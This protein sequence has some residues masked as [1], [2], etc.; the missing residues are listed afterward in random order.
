[1]SNQSFQAGTLVKRQDANGFTWVLRYTKD[2]KRKAMILGTHE[3]LPTEGHAKLKAADKI[4]LINSDKPI[5]TFGQLVER[6][7]SEELP[8]RLQTAS[9]YNSNIKHLM[10]K[11]G[12]VDLSVM[13]KDLMA[14]QSWLGDL[15]TP[16]KAN[17][18]ARPYSK[19]TKQHIKALLHRIIECA[20]RWGYLP[21][22]RNP[23]SLVEIKV[24]GIQ[25]AKRLKVPLTINQFN[26]LVGDEELPEHVR[27]MSKVALFLGLRI[28]EVLGLRWEDVDFDG[29]VVSIERSAVGK[30]LGDTKTLGS[31]SVLPLH[32]Y[33]VNTLKVW[34]KSS[35]PI[36]GWVF[37]S[38]ATGRP[39]HRD[40]LQADHL[41]PAALRCGI[42]GLGWHTFRH[43][44]I[45]ILRQVGTAPEVQMMLMRHADMRTTNSYGRDGQSLEL[46]RPANSAVVEAILQLSEGSK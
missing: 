34:Q 7:K 26:R 32:E 38:I 18:P 39:F 23:V 2:G 17:R 45:A 41:L 30:D 36:N 25:P 16:A 4:A 1:M 8:P 29:C 20:M 40:S 19:K 9:S 37:G 13:L 35:E 15:Q 27:V 22:D 6:Y 3:D 28:S 42:H 5:Y 14:I 21:I 31:R 46:K 33:I 43:T 11:W 12:T 24:K 10:A 44:H